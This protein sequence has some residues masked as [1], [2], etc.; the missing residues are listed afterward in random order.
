ME[1]ACMS[2]ACMCTRARSIQGFYTEPVVRRME[3][4]AIEKREVQQ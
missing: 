2:D 3:L 4:L 1:P